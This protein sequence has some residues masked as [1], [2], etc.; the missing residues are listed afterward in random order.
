M[1]HTEHYDSADLQIYN[2][3]EAIT[4][5]L[6]VVMTA[7]GVELADAAGEAIDGVAIDTVSAAG[8]EVT[9]ID[10]GIVLV[11]ASA[12]FANNVNLA[13]TAA[14]KFALATTGQTVVAKSRAAATAADELVPAKLLPRGQFTAP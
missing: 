4:A 13:V 14:G 1:A 10:S 5:R 7:T 11:R 12:A 8:D 2:A 6:G 3:D 9:V